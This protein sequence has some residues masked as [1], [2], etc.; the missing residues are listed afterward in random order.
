VLLGV[1]QD[2]GLIAVLLV[3]LAFAVSVHRRA[4]WSRHEPVGG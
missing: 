4:R 3:V 2:Y 1:P